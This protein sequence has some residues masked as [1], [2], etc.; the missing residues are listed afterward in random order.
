[1]AGVWRWGDGRAAHNVGHV[2][3]HA[4]ADVAVSVA[5]WLVK[6]WRASDLRVLPT[7]ALVQLGG[8]LHPPP[9][10]QPPCP[11]P[12]WLL[13]HHKWLLLQCVHVCVCADFKAGAT[14]CTNEWFFFFLNMKVASLR[15]HS[16]VLI[17]FFF[18]LHFFCVFWLWV[19]GVRRFHS[20]NSVKGA[21]VFFLVNHSFVFFFSQYMY[22]VR[23]P[24]ALNV[25]EAHRPTHP[26][27]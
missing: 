26:R 9:I 8:Q 25:S 23:L 12:W 15:T 11:P 14:L 24:E 5:G 19:E 16:A 27:I 3:R 22:P 1:M 10:L 6:G 13:R 2:R 4:A 7:G 21:M 18:N 17:F 20:L